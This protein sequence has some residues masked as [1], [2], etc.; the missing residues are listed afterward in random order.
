MMIKWNERSVRWFHNASEFTGYNKKL[1]EIRLNSIPSKKSL[2]DM[3]C[4]AALID[5]ELAKHIEKISCI[6]ISQTVIDHVE[7]QIKEKRIDNMR[8]ICM[9][10]LEVKG[11]WETV[12]A[13]FHG[14]DKVFSHY[15][16]QAKDQLILVTHGS[17]RGGFGPEGKKAIRCFGTP[18][19]CANLD[20]LGVKYHLCEFEL[21]Y[22][23]PFTDLKDAEEF[24]KAY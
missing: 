22:G 10:G 15:F 17:M 23:Q 20:S 6:D 8:A 19:V 3:G 5:F 7:Q 18:G 13:I 16:H 21:E 2:C 11:Q 12:M 24:V 9:D 4:G 14:G 1:A